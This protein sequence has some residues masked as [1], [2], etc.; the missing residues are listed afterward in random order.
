M[1][2]PTDDPVWGH[3]FEQ[4]PEPDDGDVFLD[5]EG[6]PF[7]RADA[8]LFFLFG[9]I[10]RDGRRR[11]G[12]YQA[13]WAH[14][15]DEEATAAADAHRVPRRPPRGPPRHARLPLQ[16]HRAIGARAAG[17]RPRR[18]R[19]DARPTLVETG[20]FVDLSS[21]ARNAVQVGHRVLRPQVPRAAHRLRARPRH[22]PGRRRGRRVR[23]LHE[24]PRPGRP[25]PH[26]RLQRGRRPRHA[27]PARLAGRAPTRRSAVAG[28][29]ARAGRR[30]TR[31]RRA[32]RTRC[33]PS[34]RTRPSTSSATCSATGGA[35]GRPTWLRCWP[36]AQADTADL[37]DDPEVL[38]GLTYVGMVERIGKNGQRRSTPGDAVR[39]PR[40]GDRR[41]RDRGDQVLYRDARRRRRATRRSIVLRPTRPATVDLVWSETMRASSD[42][43]PD[44]G[45]AQRLGVTRSRSPTRSPSWP[46]RVLDPAG[47]D[48]EPGRRWRCCAAT[49][50]RFAPGG[51]PPAGA[52][53]DDLD[54]MTAWA[55]QLDHSYVADPRAA[56]D[57]Q[58]LPR[59]APRPSA[60]RWPASGSASPP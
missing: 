36:G 37:L 21:V 31:A 11:A 33:T 52:F 23:A 10:L 50:P 25:R 32:G 27:R 47:R 57:G 45:G 24:R 7:W 48:A 39:A 55:T 59:R 12:R 1:I 40:P 46:P 43:L 54:E 15:R 58:D 22:R 20:L 38:A 9:L 35:S 51:G 53:T 18:R 44:R 16:P 5:F 41:L 26:R 28:R 14:D 34:A 60:D 8:G 29:R 56:G 19:G 30:P 4:L 6:H 49:C 2:E 42:V 17:R 13:W 3:G